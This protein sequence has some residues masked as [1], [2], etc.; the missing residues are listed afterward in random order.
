MAERD[1]CDELLVLKFPIHNVYN[2]TFLR[3]SGLRCNQTLENTGGV[4][5]LH[6]SPGVGAHVNSGILEESNKFVVGSMIDKAFVLT[7]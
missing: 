2:G 5:E 7:H 1:S 4:A 6:V 3:L